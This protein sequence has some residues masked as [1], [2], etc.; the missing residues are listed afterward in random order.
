MKLSVLLITYNHEKFISK[1]I[2]SILMQRDCPEFE[3]ILSDDNSSDKTFSIASNLLQAFPIKRCFSNEKNLGV[4]RNYQHSFSLCKG[5]YIFVLEGDDYWIDPFK[6]KKQVDFLDSHPLCAMCTHPFFIQNDE[7]SMFS[8]FGLNKKEVYT[9]FDCKDII[10]DSAIASNFSTCC[11]R[12]RI[13]EKLS[14][15]VYE[16]I[17]YDWMVN[18]SV[19]QYGQVGRINSLMSVYR[20][21]SQG[22]Y[23]KLSE[24]EKLNGILKMLPLYDEILDYKFHDYFETKIRLITAEL[25]P[26]SKESSNGLKKYLPSLFIAIGKLIIP[27]VIIKAFKRFKPSL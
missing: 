21:S 27:P 25:K 11:Y 8:E 1:A 15:K 4:T 13:L 19:A 5:E 10:L 20:I 9:Q 7:L 18:I 3:I 16:V 6:I 23:S 24:S 12:R 22:E 17:S 26:L 14:P 2:E